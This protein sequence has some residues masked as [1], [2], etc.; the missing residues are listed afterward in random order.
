[1]SHPN[2]NRDVDYDL[3]PTVDLRYMDESRRKFPHVCGHAGWC[4]RAFATIEEREEHMRVHG[5][6]AVEARLERDGK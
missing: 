4:W 1:M 5:L 6:S 2:D 3:V